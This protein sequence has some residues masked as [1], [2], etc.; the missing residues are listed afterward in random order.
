MADFKDRPFEPPTRE[1]NPIAVSAG[2]SLVVLAWLWFEGRGQ[3]PAPASAPTAS[4]TVA[5]PPV[6][7]PP[8]LPQRAPP[9]VAP[10]LLLQAV[11]PTAPPAWVSI[12]LCKSWQGAQFWASTPCAGHRATI[13]RIHRVPG[14]LPWAEQVAIG[15]AEA[16]EAAKLYAPPAAH[17]TAAAPA[18]DAR[19]QNRADECAL[20]DQQI[21]GYDAITRQPQSPPLLDYVRAERRKVMD[22][23]FQ[24][25]C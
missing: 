25:R 15:Q 14:S 22:R 1:L 18:H 16:Q 12:Y 10:P 24:L 7:T 13:D 20:L 2:I 4:L 9:A 6:A 17:A 23:K 5:A 3:Q 21:R 19:R 11:N 8:A